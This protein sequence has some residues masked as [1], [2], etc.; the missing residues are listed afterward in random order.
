MDALSCDLRTGNSK[1]FWKRVAGSSGDTRPNR[2]DGAVGEEA[3]ANL[4][5]NKFRNTLNSLSD[6]RERMEVTREKL[7]T[8]EPSGRLRGDWQILRGY[9]GET[10]GERGRE[11]EREHPPPPPPSPPH[12]QTSWL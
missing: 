10:A 2:I 9:W 11:R 5:A 6:T 12:T 3:V 8:G 4:W 7:D 1:E